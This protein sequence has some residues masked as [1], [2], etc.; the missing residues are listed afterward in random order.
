ML[1]RRSS[2]LLPVLLADCGG[3]EGPR[4]YPPLHYDYLT[5]LGLNVG[6]IRIEQRFVPSGAAP[7]VSQFD[8]VPPLRALRAMGEDRLQAL[9]TADQA[10]FVILDATL[11]RR[12]DTLSGNFAVELGIYTAPNARAGFAQASVSRRYTGDLDDLPGR[13]YDLT[14]DMMDR[15]N[16][17]FEYQ[18]RRAL[19]P[20][21]LSAG[22]AR[23]PVE[24]QPL[25]PEPPPAL[26]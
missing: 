25:T 7:D 14:K 3:G 6:A 16:V 18:V 9:G 1:T 21:L 24:Q 15:L 11:A 10:V 5:P 19:R 23:T 26:P 20:W 2:L 17:E 4:S 12:R 22:A 13:L 8:P